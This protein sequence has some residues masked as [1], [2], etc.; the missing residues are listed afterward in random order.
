MGQIINMIIEVFR[1][2]LNVFVIMPLKLLYSVIVKLPVNIIGG[3]IRAIYNL[4]IKT[5][6]GLINGIIGGLGI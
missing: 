5:P 4:L 1:G 6:A 3:I 2:A